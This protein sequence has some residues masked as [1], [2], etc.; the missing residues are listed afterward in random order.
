[1]L[2]QDDIN[3]TKT[4]R[5]LRL[6]NVGRDAEIFAVTTD[7]KLL[8]NRRADL[9]IA[10]EIHNKDEAISLW[11]INNDQTQSWSV[12]T[13]RLDTKFLKQDF[14]EA[15]ST[16]LLAL[17]L[18]TIKPGTPI[19]R[20]YLI[21]ALKPIAVH[22]RHLLDFTSGFT[23]TQNAALENAL[24]MTLFVIGD[25]AGENGALADAAGAFQAALQS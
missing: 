14:T 22:L 9:L 6:S 10:G 5:V 20:L 19:S 24:G 23:A 2:D 21:V 17:A 7:R 4:C 25:Q 3:H 18:A 15:A 16:Q 8:E 12:L 11:L 1:M 13:V